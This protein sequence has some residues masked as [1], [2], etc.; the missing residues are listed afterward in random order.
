MERLYSA[1]RRDLVIAIVLVFLV[2]ATRIPFRTTMLYNWDSANFALAIDHF[3]VTKHFPHPPGYFYYVMAARGINV[4]AQ[5]ANTSLVAEGIIF[6]ALAVVALYFLGKLIFDRPTGV[7]A[8]LLLTFSVTYWSLGTVALPYVSLAFFSTAMAFLAY[9]AV[10]AGVDET[11]PISVVYALGGGFRPDLMLF[12]GPLWLLSMRGRPRRRVVFGAALVVAGVM[13]WYVPTVWLSGGI[14]AYH[15]TLLAYLQVDVA[16][17]Y[18]PINKGLPALLVNVHDTLSYLFYALYFTVIP[19]LAGAA[20]AAYGYI[21]TRK[22][23]A[24]AHGGLPNAVAALHYAEWYSPQKNTDEVGEHPLPPEVGAKAQLA[25]ADGLQLGLFTTCWIAPM[26]IFYIFIHVGDPGYVF[27]IL[28][29]LLLL[30]AT[31][32][33][34][35]LTSGQSALSARPDSYPVQMANRRTFAGSELVPQRPVEMVALLTTLVLA[36]NI[37]LALFYP[38]QLTLV[39]I[40]RSDEALRTKIE[41]IKDNLPSTSSLLVSYDTYRHLQYYIPLYRSAWIDI[42]DPREQIVGIPPEATYLALVDARLQQPDLGGKY[43]A[44]IQIVP[45]EQDVNEIVYAQHRLTLRRNTLQFLNKNL[46]NLLTIHRLGS[47]LGAAGNL[48]CSLPARACG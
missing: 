19:L 8:A 30:A 16:Q 27:T 43:E 12:L 28:P 32:L 17:K 34:L 31:V 29:A 3:D 48:A 18:A 46:S 13:L 38:K 7:V 4:L 10:F 26:A 11:V 45:I 14:E 5:D 40:R 35:P 37:A 39:G 41:Y 21:R 25:G 36:G 2:A 9:R 15:S 22:S 47:T 23:L 33:T 24:F 1:R 6:S 20:Y 42:F 44:G